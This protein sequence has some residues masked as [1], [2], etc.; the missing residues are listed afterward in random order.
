MMEIIN[1][2]NKSLA[3]GVFYGGDAGA[4]EA[5]IYNDAVWMIKY[6]KTTRDMINPKV[7]YTTS[8]LS[9]YLG[10]KIYELLGFPTHEVLLGTK[11]NKLVVACKDFTK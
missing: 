2:D 6:P 10:S 11:R 4:K 8:P 5:I 7:S 3:P 9:E 1:F